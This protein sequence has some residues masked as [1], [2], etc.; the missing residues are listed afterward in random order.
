MGRQKVVEQMVA[1]HYQHSILGRLSKESILVRGS[2]KR[3]V[4]T[5]FLREG[6]VGPMPNP[7][8]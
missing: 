2:G 5:L 4:T 6:I 7:Q 1:K 8:A 3:F